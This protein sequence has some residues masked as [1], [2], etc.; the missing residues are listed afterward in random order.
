MK[1]YINNNL[2]N[3]VHPRSA[4]SGGTEKKGRQYEW[5]QTEDV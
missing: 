2:E 3:P 1:A 5:K 4:V